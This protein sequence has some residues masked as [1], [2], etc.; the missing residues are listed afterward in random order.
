M[1]G[2][3][4]VLSERGLVIILGY[5]TPRLLTGKKAMIKKVSRVGR[6]GTSLPSPA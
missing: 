1:I 3:N 4:N 6:E 2:K 5:K